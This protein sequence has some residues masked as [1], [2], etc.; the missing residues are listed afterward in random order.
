MF[1]TFV[2]NVMEN[3]MMNAKILIVDDSPQIVDILSNA[4]SHYTCRVALNGKN[5]LKLAL[6]DFMPDL[7]LLDINLP[8]MSGFDIIKKLKQNPKTKDIPVIF[9]T[10]YSN[11]DNQIKCFELGGVDYITKPISIPVLLAR[12]KNHLELYFSKE[13]LKQ[14]N[15]QLKLMGQLREEIEKI[16]QHDMKSPL[17]AIIGFSKMLIDWGNL[18]ERNLKMAKSIWN[19][20]ERLIK[21]INN[22]LD[23]YKLETGDFDKVLK[24]INIIPILYSA[25]N[26]FE[27]L[28]NRKRLRITIL[29]NNRIVSENDALNDALFVYGEENLLFMLFSNLIK[30]AIEASPP[31]EEIVIKMFDS[32]PVA[33]S[34]QNKGAVPV[35]IRDRFFDKHITKGK[36]GGTGLGTYSAKLITINLMGQIDMTTS[37]KEG[38]II[39]LNFPKKE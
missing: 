28:Y 21:M 13:K 20:G 39:R 38:T 8:D 1:L 4:L 12:V 19:A 36:L 26:E 11:I 30:N 33:I 7:I 14:Q 35:E 16:T 25:I 17:T 34:I 9:L 10:G 24:K 15:K 5:A 27:A 18:D 37:D 31:E 22:S 6:S 2:G 29:F 23:L 3:L 32:D